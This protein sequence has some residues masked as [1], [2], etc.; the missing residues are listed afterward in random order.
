MPEPFF[1][2]LSTLWIIWD[3]EFLPVGDMVYLYRRALKE[4]YSNSSS[5]R[6]IEELRNT[7]ISS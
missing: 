4:S 6:P 5:R 1:M 3:Q 7:D 2:F